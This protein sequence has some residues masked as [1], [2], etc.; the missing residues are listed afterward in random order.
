MKNAEKIRRIKRLRSQLE[1][2]SGHHFGAINPCSDKALN[3][4]GF[5]T[6]CEICDGIIIRDD[7]G[8]ILTQEVL[9]KCAGT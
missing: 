5:I 6:T 8:F 2:Q 4:K 7:H 3:S 1:E 9:E